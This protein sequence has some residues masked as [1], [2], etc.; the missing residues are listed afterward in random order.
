MYLCLPA[1][2]VTTA[3]RRQCTGVFFPL[4]TLW[5]L[6]SEVRRSSRRTISSTCWA[7]SS[8]P[9][10][11]SLGHRGKLGLYWLCW[12]SAHFLPSLPSL[13]VPEVS[14]RDL[15]HSLANNHA[16]DFRVPPQELRPLCTTFADASW[17]LEVRGSALR[18]LL[19][20]H[21]PSWF[22]VPVAILG[23]TR[24]YHHASFIW[25]WRQT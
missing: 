5:A 11:C 9:S 1:P 2:T 13:W 4:P 17:L 16:Q 3:V 10:S 15:I 19:L 21:C 23:I 8:V 6:G 25:R 12:S 20:S 7:I 18:R 22:R 14:Q 24:L